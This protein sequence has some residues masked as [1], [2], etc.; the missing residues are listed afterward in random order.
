MDGNL[1]KIPIFEFNF[2]GMFI[3]F[4]SQNLTRNSNLLFLIQIEARKI[5]SMGL[6][7]ENKG[8]WAPD[9]GF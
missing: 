5:F 1:K 7:R 8:K 4:L 3:H 9:F 6:L 2:T